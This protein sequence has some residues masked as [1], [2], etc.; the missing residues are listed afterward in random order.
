MN[1]KI[2]HQLISALPRGAVDRDGYL[3]ID[4]TKLEEAGEYICHATDTA[5]GQE[6]PSP[7]G[8]LHVKCNNHH[9]T[10][11]QTKLLG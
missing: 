2:S 9:H 3:K 10:D 6:Q 5:T 8:T 7:V 11:I 4:K 1:L